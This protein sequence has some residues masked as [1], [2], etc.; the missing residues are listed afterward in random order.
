[1][2]DKTL[3]EI[4]AQVDDAEKG[5]NQDVN[6][7]PSSVAATN[8]ENADALKGVV[9]QDQRPDF[10]ANL[11]PDAMD[12]VRLRTDEAPLPD[13]TTKKPE[14]PTEPWAKM[15]YELDQNRTRVPP[16]DPLVSKM[17]SVGWTPS[18]SAAEPDWEAMQK[19]LVSA[20]RA[21]STGRSVENML[22]NAGNTGAYRTDPGRFEEQANIAKVPLE[23]AQA[24]QGYEKGQ[25]ALDTEK[26]KGAAEKAD[27]DPTSPVSERAR[28]AYR[29]FFKGSP[30]PEGFDQF[31]AEDVKR[32]AEDPQA[33]V[34]KRKTEEDLQAF[35]LAEA[36]KFSRAADAAE[37]KQAAA[38]AKVAKDAADEAGSMAIERQ[39]V[40]ADPRLQ[41]IPN[42][43]TGKPFTAEDLNGLDRKGLAAVSKQ[44]ESMPKVKGGATAG[45]EK[46]V[47][48]GD[49]SAVPANMRE[50]VRAIAE[51]REPPPPPG[52]RYGQAILNYVTRVKPDFDATGHVRYRAVAEQTDKD[53]GITSALIAKEHFQRALQKIPANYDTNVVN[54]IVND[55]KAGGGSPNMSEFETDVAVGAGELS[56]GLGENAE[57]GK[58][59]IKRLLSPN[60]SPAQLRAHLNELIFLQDEGLEAKRQKFESVAPVG[61]KLPAR[62]ARPPI[63]MKFPNG[64]THDVAAEE[65]EMAKKKG[66]VPQ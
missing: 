29:A 17:K 32:F 6:T 64:E 60:Q 39:V 19:Q 33:V 3:E 46:E 49:Y 54:R 53:T 42:P 44:L 16:E 36:N 63:K 5:W 8:G 40:A 2:A 35:R 56:K 65:V 26:E 27:R 10:G 11:K 55:I 34:S 24:R 30:E 9:S 43:A 20:Q 21:A 25:E 28:N 1:M 58:E 7:P 57:A 4:L 59:S 13:A 48:P 22:A 37:A 45:A 52:S 31:S 15:G 50:T 38:D 62:L 23:I 66:G 61:A 14:A 47:K 12:P 51:Y 18:V 41:R